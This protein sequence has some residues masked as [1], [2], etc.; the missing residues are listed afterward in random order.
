AFTAEQLD[1]NNHGN[2]YLIGV[3]R[4]KTGVS[5]AQARAEMDTLAD[6]LRPQFY[7]PNSKWGLTLVPIREELVGDFRYPLLVLFIAVACVLLIACVNVANL[8]L[9]R[10]SARQKELSIRTALGA[11]RLR[12]VRQLLTES[13]L[14]ALL[15][16]ALGL[17][18]AYGGIKL[19]L[20]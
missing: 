3:A 15:G 17:L 13:L 5:L 19:L 8:L 18:I 1:P 7:G 2:E 9:A 4:I 10:A 20:L 12:L 14:L 6:Q 16:G 11:R